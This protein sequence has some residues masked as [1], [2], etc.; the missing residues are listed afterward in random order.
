MAIPVKQNLVLVSKYHIKCPNSMTPTSI[1]VHNTY[2]DASAEAEI[3]YMI[4]NDK[5][6]SFHIAVDGEE[7]ILGIPLNRN[8]WAAG[9]GGKGPGNRSS[10]HIEICYSKSGGPRYRAAE[11]K[12][13][14]LIA[15]MLKERGWG[16]ERVKK[17][18]DWSGKYCPHR[19]LSEGRWGDF[20]AAV[21]KELARLNQPATKPAA[22][23]VTKPKEEE[24]MLEKAVVIN[25]F[26][27][28]PAAERLAIKLGAPIYLRSVAKGKKVAK[29]LYVVGGSKEGIVADKVTLLSGPDRFA[30]AQ[31]V[32]GFLKK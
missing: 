12:T 17:H 20:R 10:I 23:P 27:D 14:K 8:A 29:E 11:S 31:A 21:A 1:T 13:I 15:Q 25:G 7:A 19:I 26:E 5:E 30:T 24:D 9:D 3:N 22:K 6:V 32:G 18:Q 16:V 28:F 2:N 4:S